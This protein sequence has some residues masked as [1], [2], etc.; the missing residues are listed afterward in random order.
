MPAVTAAAST[1]S[2]EFVARLAERALD[3]GRPPATI[4]DLIASRFTELLVPARYGGMQADFPSILDPVRRMA[5]GCA[6]S[7]L[8]D[9]FLR[10]AQPDAGAVR[11][12]RAGGGVRD[13][14]V[15]RACSPGTGGPG[16]ADG[17]G[18]PA[19]GPVVVGTGVMHGNWIIVGALCG[20]DDGIYPSPRVGARRRHPDR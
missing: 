8:D 19:D 2:P 11:P 1:I 14:A 10:A 5:H 15:P 20:P 9:R 3:A 17:R 16:R 13:A 7:A 4:D 6:S 12:A 18:R